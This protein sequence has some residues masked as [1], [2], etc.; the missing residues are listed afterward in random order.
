MKLDDFIVETDDVRRMRRI[1]V[2]IKIADDG[3]SIKPENPEER[4]S[5][6]ELT[7]LS[8]MAYMYAGSAS[9][10][11]TADKDDIVESGIR[12]Y[13]ALKR[14]CRGEYYGKK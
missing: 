3:I 11:I 14:S 13:G 8:A 7:S 5:L 9:E 1:K 12:L 4:L 2:I 10:G 6:A